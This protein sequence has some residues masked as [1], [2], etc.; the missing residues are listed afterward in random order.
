MARW[1]CGLFIERPGLPTGYLYQVCCISNHRVSMNVCTEIRYYRTIDLF[2]LF[3]VIFL[4]PFH[5][6][7]AIVLNNLA[8]TPALRNHILHSTL[9]RPLI[10]SNK[11]SSVPIPHISGTVETSDIAR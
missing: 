8:P 4:L 1:G 2:Q 9:Y 3:G 10:L 7:A 5:I 6:W 11:E